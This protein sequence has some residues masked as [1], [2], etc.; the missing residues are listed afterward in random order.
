MPRL[1]TYTI[2]IDDGAAPNPF[3]GMCSLAI[4]KPSIRRVAEVGDWVAGLGSMHAAGGNRYGQLVYAMKV[5][6]ILS[7]E[8]YDRFALECWPYRIPNT[9]SPNVKERLGDCIYDFSGGIPRQRKGVHDE[10]NRETDLGGCNVLLSWDF[11]YFGN[12]AVP[13]PPNLMDI[14]HQTQGHKSDS[15][16]PFFQPFV[17]WIRRQGWMPTHLY[18]QPDFQ[19]DWRDGDSRY[20]SCRV[21]RED[22]HNDPGCE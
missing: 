2:P 5:E 4:C 22:A 13:L 9:D 3:D 14:C 8:E 15:N 6:K 18:G 1:F 12:E 19:I 17:D 21:R 10:G 11:Y 16:A 7:M 20:K